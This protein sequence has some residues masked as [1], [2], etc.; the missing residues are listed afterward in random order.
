MGQSGAPLHLCLLVL[1]VYLF[2]LLLPARFVLASMHHPTRNKVFRKGESKTYFVV[3]KKNQA[4]HRRKQ[5]KK[6]KKKAMQNMRVNN[7]QLQSRHNNGTS[8]SF[9]LLMDGRRTCYVCCLTWTWSVYVCMYA[10]V[11]RQYSV[12]V[13][14]TCAIPFP[15]SVALQSFAM[16]TPKR[17]QV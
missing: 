5:G 3:H 6:K 15:S 12:H 8:V 1:S 17:H 13:Y 2:F 10:F 7:K 4:R 11:W 9:D 14:Y 16:R